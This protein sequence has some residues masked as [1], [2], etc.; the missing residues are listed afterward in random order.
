MLICEKFRDIIDVDQRGSPHFPRYAKPDGP[1]PNCPTPNRR[2]GCLGDTGRDIV[3][4]HQAVQKIRHGL[5]F[6]A[7]SFA[8][9]FALARS[10]QLS[11][12]SA[13]RSTASSCARLRKPWR[14]VGS[15]L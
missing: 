5:L 8:L 11:P 15:S 3:W 4:C 1:L 14:V 9:I 2:A 10:I 12:Q 6:F 7:A 13:A